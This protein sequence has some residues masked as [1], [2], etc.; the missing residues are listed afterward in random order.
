M[1]TFNNGVGREVAN[2]RTVRIKAPPGAERVS[3]SAVS[4]TGGNAMERDTKNILI[5]GNINILHGSKW[6]TRTNI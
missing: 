3:V 5:I 6:S 4:N 2:R 1:T